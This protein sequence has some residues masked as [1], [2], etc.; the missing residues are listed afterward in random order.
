MIMRLIFLHAGALDFI[1][2]TVKPTPTS[3]LGLLGISS[4]AESEIIQREFS[5]FAPPSPR[6]RAPASAAAA[7]AAAAAAVASALTVATYGDVVDS[8]TVKQTL[9]V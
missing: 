3:A 9:I 7:A 5:P 1:F 4:T 8:W 6:A 2:T